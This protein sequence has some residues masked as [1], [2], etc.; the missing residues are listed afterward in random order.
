MKNYTKPVLKK[1]EETKFESI[2]ASSG[3]DETTGKCLK[4]KGIKRKN[5]GCYHSGHG[6]NR[7]C[8]YFGI[9]TL[10]W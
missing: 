5:K 6:G 4:G 7:P 3:L 10:P 8:E 2:Y 9:C 1:N